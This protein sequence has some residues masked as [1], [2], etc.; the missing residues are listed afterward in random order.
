M[1]TSTESRPK[2][3]R[4]V[5]LANGAD[6]D[7]TADPNPPPPPPAPQHVAEIAHAVHGRIRLRIPA[8]KRDPGILGQLKAAI[9]GIGG[10]D[11]VEVKPGSASL[12][13][14]YDSEHHPEVGAFLRLLHQMEAAP[15][16]LAPHPEFAPARPPQ[17]RV[18][19]LTANIE[20]EAEFLAEHSTLAKTVVAAV[21]RL[22]KDIKR[23]T[24]NNLDLKIMV[25]VAL[26]GVT[27]LEI[28]AAAATPMW[29]TLAIFS[30]NHFVELHAHDSDK[31]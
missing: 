13:V 1:S 27:F 19:E 20:N 22:D 25:P 17:N 11:A 31:K 23:S 26:A 6:P 3:A 15:V 10:I 14:Y 12:V 8:A 18:D 9:G 4:K 16:A 5:T 30:L 24:N 7:A 29:I 2:A 21:K 28:G